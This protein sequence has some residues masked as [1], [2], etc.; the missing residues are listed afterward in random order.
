MR[1][2]IAV[3][4]LALIG[5][6]GACWAINHIQD[7][8]KQYIATCPYK[9]GMIVKNKLDGR[10]GI[11]TCVRPIAIYVKYS[12]PNAEHPYSY[13][14]CQPNEIELELEK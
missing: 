12:T 5:V 10:R 2:A 1:S 3:I 13:D 7:R 4:V 8:D 11:I 9:E 14:S 6:F